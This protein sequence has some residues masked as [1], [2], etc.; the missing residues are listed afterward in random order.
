MSTSVWTFRRDAYGGALREAAVARSVRLRVAAHRPVARLPVVE[1]AA[2]LRSRF[3]PSAT[4]GVPAHVTVLFPFVPPERLD[5]QV[6]SRV[7][8]AVRSVPPFDCAFLRTAWFPGDVLYLAPEPG[9]PFRLLTAAVFAAFPE[10]PPYDGAYDDIVPHLT[11]GHPPLGTSTQLRRAEAAL[12]PQ[13]P[14]RTRV[15]RAW[16]M[17]GTPVPGSWRVLD[18]LPLGDPGAA[19]EGP[20]TPAG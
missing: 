11:I 2:S 13:L 4:R 12:A 18:E 16:L 15:D 17:S 9:E 3:D 5:P 20:P 8:A 6:V 14:V 10:F 7:A 1:R 19:R